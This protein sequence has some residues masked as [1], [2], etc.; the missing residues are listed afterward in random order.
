MMKSL[1]NNAGYKVKEI[2]SLSLDDLDLIV[3]LNEP[4]DEK[5]KPIDKAFPFLFH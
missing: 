3:R 4:E 5:E 1:Q 2:L